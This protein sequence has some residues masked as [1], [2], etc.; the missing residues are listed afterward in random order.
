MK[1]RLEHGFSVCIGGVPG[2]GKTS[3]LEA[4][5]R[6]HELRDRHLIGSSIVKAIIA[7]SSVRELDSWPAARRVAVREAA[8]TKLRD[9]R[10][11][12]PGRLL[13]DGHFTLRNRTTRTVE[14]IFTP[15]DRAFY[16]ALLLLDARAE[17]VE[18]WRSGDTRIREQESLAE[19]EEHL[20]AEREEAARLA[21][22]MGVPFLVLVVPTLS[23]RLRALSDFLD[24][25]AQLS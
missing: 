8:I 7:P 20:A 24:T 14:P 3:L 19:I 18:S 16:D 4:H 17:L 12:T 23:D 11:T 6:G 1:L 13:V 10:R 5:V 25:H 9:V 21:A 22:S 2:V 15:G